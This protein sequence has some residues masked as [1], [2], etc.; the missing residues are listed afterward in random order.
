M[1]SKNKKNKSV[2]FNPN[3]QINNYTPEQKTGTSWEQVARDRNRFERKTKN[4]GEIVE[5]VLDAKHRE[6]IFKERFSNK[7]Q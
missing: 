2:G 1:E 4:I 3:L 6:K 5:P 7:Y